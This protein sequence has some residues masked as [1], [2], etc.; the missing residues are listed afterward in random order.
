M[1]ETKRL[2]NAPTFKRCSAGSNPALSANSH[3]NRGKPEV[4]V[5]KSVFKNTFNRIA[6]FLFFVFPMALVGCASVQKDYDHMAAPDYEKRPELHQSLI[7]G[8]EP[9]SEAAVQRTRPKG[10]LP[11]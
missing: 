3:T 7:N 11:F 8:T 10:S 2:L 1:A 5:F 4:N 9:L 6:G